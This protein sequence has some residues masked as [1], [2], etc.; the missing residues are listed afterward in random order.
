MRPEK[1][2]STG[3]QRSHIYLR[4]CILK[5]RATS[6]KRPERRMFDRNCSPPRTAQ[7]HGLSTSAPHRYF[8]TLIHSAPSSTVTWEESTRASSA[9]D[10]SVAAIVSPDVKLE[11]P[12]FGG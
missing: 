12:R 10:G 6:R 2:R 1:S 3:Y 4:P 7:T 9:P 8:Q 11:L 5:Y